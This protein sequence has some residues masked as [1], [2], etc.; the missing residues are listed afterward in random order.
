MPTVN[1]RGRLFWGSAC[2]CE[3]RR[4]NSKVR[5]HFGGSGLFVSRPPPVRARWRTSAAGRS[6]RD[7][8]PLMLSQLEPYLWPVPPL[9]ASK[10]REYILASCS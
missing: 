3:P 5:H 4:G 1:N 6:V 8:M 9:D 2:G 10:F 7:P